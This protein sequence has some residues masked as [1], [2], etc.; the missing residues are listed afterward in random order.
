MW[1]EGLRSHFVVAGLRRLNLI[2]LQG[3]AGEVFCRGIPV[4]VVVLLLLHHHL[5]LLLLLLVIGLVVN[6]ELNGA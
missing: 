1:A 3:V 5:L 6:C 4:L 2:F